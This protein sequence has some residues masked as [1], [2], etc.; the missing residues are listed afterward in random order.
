MKFGNHLIARY[1]VAEICACAYQSQN[2]L[3]AD[4]LVRQVRLEL[5][6]LS[7]LASKTSMYT[8]PPLAHI[9]CPQ[10]ESN[11]YL[12]LRRNLFYPLNHRDLYLAESRGVEPHPC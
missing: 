3:S 1:L 5:T 10:Q 8:I 2:L 4:N 7:A 11:L 6:I 9:W 12:I